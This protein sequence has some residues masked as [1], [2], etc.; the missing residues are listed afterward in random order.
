M[1]ANTIIN[2]MAHTGFDV[3]VLIVLV[4][5][6]RRIF[7]NI[8]GARA[9]YSLW[10]LPFVRL[11]LP[12]ISLVFNRPNWMQSVAQPS[13]ENIANTMITPTSLPQVDTVN[14]NL[15]IVAIW[16]LGAVFF[17][18]LHVWR[19]GK[20][21]RH[22]KNNSQPAAL[23][24]QEIMGKAAEVLDLREVPDVRISADNIGPLVTGVI[25]PVIILPHHFAHNY[26]HQQ[27]LLALTHELAHVKRRDLWAAF[28]ML[29][30]RTINWPNPLVHYSAAKFRTDQEAA[31]DAY[32]LKMMGGSQQVKQSYAATLIHSAKLTRSLT[33]HGQQI[34]PLCLTIS[35]P[36]KERLMTLKTSKNNT[37]LLSRIGVTSFLVAACIGTAPITFAT[38][39]GSEHTVHVKT[40]MKKV[41][42]FVEN[43]DGVETKKH[44]EITTEDGKT[45][46]VSIDENGNKTV[47][48][49]DELE[50]LPGLESDE[51]MMMFMSDSEMGEGDGHLKIIM[52]SN[53]DNM[54][55]VRHSS[56]LVQRGENWNIEDLE[57]SDV[58]IVDGGSHASA[59]VKAAKDLL[60]RAEDM[61]SDKEISKDAQKKIKKARKALQ[62]A[63]KALEA[64]E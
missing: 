51:H 60:D 34:S 24:I 7:A 10:L 43:N 19:Q 21:V 2:W 15:P 36:L 63:Q 20:F 62:E 37:S 32:V 54:S 33:G 11:I 8:F 27:Q 59:M 55:E 30:F 39:Q 16:G 40:K 57:D 56:M 29:I 48:D 61:S 38:E 12:E 64:S 49:L 13:Y 17:L 52:S 6:C 46:I 23:C 4:L 28:V 26:N 58:F 47:L 25:K 1:N 45:T 53:G 3:S 44:Y 35:H 42:K 41:I 9:A 50:G 31:C 5:L 22:V 14:I 18:V